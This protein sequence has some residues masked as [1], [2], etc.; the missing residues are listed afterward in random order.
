MNPKYPIFIPSKGRWKSRMTVKTLEKIGVSYTIIV[1]EQEYEKYHRYI[2]KKNILILDNK[3]QEE[4]EPC[5][6]LGHS[7]S[8]GSGPARNFIWDTAIKQGAKYH[9]IMDDNIGV[10]YRLNRNREIRCGDGTFFRV[11]EDFVERYENVLMAGPNYEQF[12]SR[13]SKYP[14]FVLNTR[15][16]SCNLIRNDAPFRWR[17]RYNEDTDLSLRMLKDGYCT[18]LF[19]AFLQD[20]ATTQTVKGGNTDELYKKGTLEKS[21]MIVRLHPDVAR[22]TWRFG[23]IHHYVNYRSFK[24]NKLIKKKDYTSEKYNLKI[25][26]RSNK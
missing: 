22:L 4:Y 5:D 7:M 14:P 21:Q 15:I 11:M 13:K 3:Y 26:T 23:R 19:N 2:D 1:E 16:Y 18:I 6:N 25:V 24:R 8:M 20:K 10:F 12:V 9:W 17:G